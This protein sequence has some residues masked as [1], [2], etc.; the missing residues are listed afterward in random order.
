METFYPPYYLRVIGLLLFIV[1]VVTWDLLRRPR[2]STRLMEYSF[3]HYVIALE[4]FGL[5]D[6]SDKDMSQATTRLLSAALD[7]FQK[8]LPTHKG[9]G[10]RVVS[11]DVSRWDRFALVPFFLE[12]ENVTTS[13]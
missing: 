3:L 9:G 2:R 1:C 11:H 4:Q 10:W 8:H 13:N 7:Q 6:P 12:R 5:A